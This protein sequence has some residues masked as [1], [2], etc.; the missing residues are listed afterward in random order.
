MASGNHFPAMGGY[1]ECD[2]RRASV[3]FLSAGVVDTGRAAERNCAVEARGLRLHLGCAGGG[4]RVNVCAGATL[5]RA[6]RCHLCGSFLCGESL[7]SGHR[8]LAQRVCGIAGQ[9]PVAVTVP[10]GAEGG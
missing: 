10:A 8:L 9:L 6:A 1:G 3:S 5:A 4:G 7:S 2:L